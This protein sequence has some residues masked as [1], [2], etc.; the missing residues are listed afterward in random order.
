MRTKRWVAPLSFAVLAAACFHQVVNTGRAPGTT[1]VD[2][3]FVATWLWGLVPAEEID[4]RRECP[5]GAAVIE[6]EQSFMNGLV[7]ALT[8]GIYTPQHVRITCASGTASAPDGAR[9]M[10]L[11]ASATPAEYHA[12]MTKAVNEAIETGNPVVIHY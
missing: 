1:V 3:P 8:I 12:F 11:A 7:A 6:T 10:R 9:Q 2:K 5:M 4:V